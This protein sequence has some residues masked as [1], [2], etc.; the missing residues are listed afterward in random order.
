M[1]SIAN[2]KDNEDI[3][4][5]KYW[6]RRDKLKKNVLSIYTL[7]NRGQKRKINGLPNKIISE[8]LVDI[9]LEDN[10]SNYNFSRLDK[11]D[12]EYISRLLIMS[13]G[14][15]TNKNVEKDVNRYYLSFSDIQKRLEILIGQIESG[16]V[17]NPEIKNEISD[18]INTL[19]K[20]GILSSYVCKNLIKK[21]VY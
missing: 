9:L 7:S 21:Y 15:L 13:G 6:I 14:N 3:K 2:S 10:K 11:D 19:E 8:K 4:F 16:N 1:S 20:A 5:G 18:I 12:K 17:D